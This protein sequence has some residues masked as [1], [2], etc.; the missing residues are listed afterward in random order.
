M[1]FE[2]ENKFG[3]P[4]SFVGTAISEKSEKTIGLFSILQEYAMTISNM[5]ILICI[6]K[7]WEHK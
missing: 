4:L 2:E 7:P 5:P 3:S 1:F 6:K